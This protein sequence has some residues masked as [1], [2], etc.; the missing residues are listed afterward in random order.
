MF[1]D[2][3]LLHTIYLSKYLTTL[4]RRSSCRRNYNLSYIAESRCFCCHCC[5]WYSC[6]CRD[7]RYSCNCI[8]LN[9]DG[10]DLRMIEN[11]A[12][13]DVD[14]F[15][16]SLDNE[17][18]N[19]KFQSLFLSMV[20]Q[21]MAITSSLCLCLSRHV[22]LEGMS[23]SL[24]LSGICLR[25]T[26]RIECSWNQ[27][28]GRECRFA[29]MKTFVKGYLEAFPLCRECHS[30]SLADQKSVKKEIE[31][32]TT[33]K[34]VWNKIPLLNTYYFPCSAFVQN[35]TFNTNTLG[36]FFGMERRKHCAAHEPQ[37]ICMTYF[38][39]LASFDFVMLPLSIMHLPVENNT[40]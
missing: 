18:M 20:T 34:Y 7:W 25:K 39:L 14:D 21:M 16:T 22:L 30:W 37:D 11:V 13:V 33:S 1:Q 24:G 10:V 26:G 40:Q 15:V 4:G 32:N 9:T 38:I 35:Y 36:T 27:C 6:D 29:L 8:G 12:A 28:Y 5:R 23:L 17:K 2:K 19:M 3:H 31:L